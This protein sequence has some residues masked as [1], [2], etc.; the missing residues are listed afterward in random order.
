MPNG[1][2]CQRCK[3]EVR[4]GP[5]CQ[6][7]VSKLKAHGYA[8]CRGENHE[9]PRAI[10]IHNFDRNTSGIKKLECKKC[11]INLCSCGTPISI[12]ARW[13]APCKKRVKAESD[14]RSRA[15][16]REKHGLLSDGAIRGHYV[17]R[18]GRRFIPDDELADKDYNPRGEAEKEAA[19]RWLLRSELPKE[20]F[21]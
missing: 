14:K 19:V 6:S 5:I 15:K 8:W 17:R 4:V 11:A 13:C 16:W 9:G 10:P 2:T 1:V 21:G 7:C 20:W 18:D 3:G 12:R